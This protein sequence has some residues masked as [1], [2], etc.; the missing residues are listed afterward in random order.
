MSESIED[1]QK[2]RESL[3]GKYV[4]VQDARYQSGFI[5]YLQDKKYGLTNWTKFL[6]NAQGFNSRK[7]AQHVANKFMYNN[8]RVIQIKKQEGE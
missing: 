8:P 1:R 6:S 2:R 7:E 4:V 5:L 3:I